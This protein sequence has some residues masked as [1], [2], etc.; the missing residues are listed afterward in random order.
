MARERSRM[1]RLLTGAVRVTVRLVWGELAVLGL[2]LRV[3]IWGA[4]ALEHAVFH[5]PPWLGLRYLQA[6]GTTIGPE[7]DFHGR[8]N[9]HGAYEPRGKLTVGRQVHIGPG[10]TLDLIAPIVLEDRC[11]ISLNSHILTHLDV[12]YSPLARKAYPTVS[13]GVTVEEGAYI[14]AGAII[15]HGIRIGRCA[16]VAAGA[17]V[18]EDVPPFTVVGGIPARILKT[19]DPDVLDLR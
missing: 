13:G 17:V 14:G 9:L 15:L 18:R 1:S 7:I 19:L 8:L 4:A 11:T 2:R 5:A 16:V 12:G 6:F 3:W 10:V